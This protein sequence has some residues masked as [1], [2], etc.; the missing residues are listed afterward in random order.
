M[1]LCPSSFQSLQWAGY[2]LEALTFNADNGFLEAILRG[3]KSN[4]LSAA[5]YNNLAQCDT[6]DDIKVRGAREAH[7][8]FHTSGV[9]AQLWRVGG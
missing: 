3:Y 7:H 8:D 9:Q 6:L 2:G 1:S 4:L 5:D